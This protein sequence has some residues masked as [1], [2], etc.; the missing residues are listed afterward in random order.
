VQLTQAPYWFYNG[1]NYYLSSASYLR[2]SHGLVSDYL[3]SDLSD[4]LRE[5][6]KIP[7]EETAIKKR[8]GGTE[9]AVASASKRSKKAAGAA[10][11]PEE[12]YTKEYNKKKLGKTKESPQ[13]AKQKALARSAEGSKNI[14]AFFKKK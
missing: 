2:Y 4:Q 6:L 3:E 8:I 7:V 10:E 9:G 12:D 13:N 5:H 1:I 11:Q 14:S